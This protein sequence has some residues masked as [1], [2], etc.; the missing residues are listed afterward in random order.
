MPLTE[1]LHKIA[2][3]YQIYSDFIIVF[4]ICHSKLIFYL[5]VNYEYKI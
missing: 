2:E 4:L 1:F 3:I 5:Q